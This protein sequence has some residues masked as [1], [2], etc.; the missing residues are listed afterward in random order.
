[1]SNFWHWTV[2]IVVVAHIIAYLWLLFATSKKKVDKRADNTTGHVWDEDLTELDNPMPR[3]WLWL[4]VITI[5]FSIAYLYLYPG[6]GNFKGS[7]EWTQINR[8][9][10]N[11]AKVNDARDK[12]FAGFINK[13][14]DELIQ[15]DQ[16][17]LLGQRIFANN[18]AQ[19]HGSDAGGA[20]GFPNLNDDDWNWGGE[21]AD[22]LY[23]LNN[24]RMGVMPPWAPA[25]GDDGVK[26]VAAYVRSLSGIDH[27]GALAAEGEAKFGMFC[28]ACHGPEGKGIAALGAPN[29]TDDIWLYGSHEIIETA[30][31][32]GLNGNMPSQSEILDENRI[33]LV[34]AYVYS[35]SNK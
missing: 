16:A 13:P 17:M 22:I 25:L 11:Y 10:A 15:D 2:I 12:S 1:M 29:L 5:V 9:E 24:G 18:C 30:L 27:D 32:E 8:F 20:T 31:Y 35:L 6:M 21:Y 19:C 33:K 7:K 26:Q 3:W 14:L 28:V 34:A 4:F 23:T